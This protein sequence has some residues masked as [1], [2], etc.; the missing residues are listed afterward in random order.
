VTTRRSPRPSPTDP[1]P[2]TPTSG[3]SSAN[4]RCRCTRLQSRPI[5]NAAAWAGTAGNK[6]RLA[7]RESTNPVTTLL[8]EGLIALAEAVRELD[9]ELEN[10]RRCRRPNRVQA[11]AQHPLFGS[12]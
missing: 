4:H 8:A 2:Q 12:G 7:A 5:S 3:S 6:F 10:V 11:A 1:P 9:Q